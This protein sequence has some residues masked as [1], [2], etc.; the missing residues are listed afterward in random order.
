MGPFCCNET[1]I[2]SEDESECVT[3]EKNSVSLV[4]LASTTVI[5]RVPVVAIR[6]YLSNYKFLV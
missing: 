4:S 5:L 2:K 6:F 1:K 3:Y